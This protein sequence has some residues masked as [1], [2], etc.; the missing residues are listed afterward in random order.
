MKVSPIWVASGFIGV[1]ELLAFLEPQLLSRLALEG[2]DAR[3]QM[4]EEFFVD[5][6]WLGHTITSALREKICKR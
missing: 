1:D 4:R 6:E 3:R 2:F 5:V